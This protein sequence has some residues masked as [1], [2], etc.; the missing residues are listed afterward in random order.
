MPKIKITGFLFV[1]AMLLVA[2]PAASGAIMPSTAAVPA[3]GDW[4]LAGIAAL[5]AVAAGRALRNRKR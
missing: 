2:G 1:S 3:L 5:L 4:G